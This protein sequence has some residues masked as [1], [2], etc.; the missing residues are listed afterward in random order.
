MEGR[1]V[2]WVGWTGTVGKAVSIS[3]SLSKPDGTFSSVS[4]SV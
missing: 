2:G 4:R 1:Q 3:V